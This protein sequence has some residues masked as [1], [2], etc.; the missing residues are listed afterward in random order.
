MS[1]RVLALLLLRRKRFSAHRA[2]MRLTEVHLDV[3]FHGLA[4]SKT[5]SA[6]FATIRFLSG[7]DADVLHQLKRTAQH[8]SANLADK[9][10]STTGRPI[11]ALLQYSVLAHML[12]QLETLGKSLRANGAAERQCEQRLI[13]SLNLLF[14][15]C[16]GNIS[17]RV[18]HEF[19]IFGQCSSFAFI[20]RQNF[21]WNQTNRCSVI[22]NL[23]QESLADAKVSARQQCVYEDP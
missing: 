17:I 3:L 9:R 23:L 2:E 14:G 13:I 4:A 21:I 12:S 1:S 16:I 18:I 10:W 22:P 6:V 19:G 5:A 8:L 11:T 7:V 15:R 20:F